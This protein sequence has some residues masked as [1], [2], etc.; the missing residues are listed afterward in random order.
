METRK[1]KL[2]LSAGALALS[3]ALAGCGGGG[4]GGSPTAVTDPPP[5]T[6]AEIDRDE[7]Q[8]NERLLGA[9]DTAEDALGIATS[10]LMTLADDDKTDGSA[11][12][13]AMKYSEM[14]DTESVDGNSKAAMD[15][16]AMVL[17]ARADLMSYI[18]MTETAITDLKTARD[19]L[20]DGSDVAEINA[21]IK[22]A[23]DLVEAAQAVLD[24]TGSGSLAHYVEMVTGDDEDDMKDAADKGMEVAMAVAMALGPAMPEGGNVGDQ[25]DGAGTRVNTDRDDTK[26]GPDLANVKMANRA[27][28]PSHDPMSMTWEQIVGAD[29]VMDMRI[30]SDENDTDEVKAASFDGMKASA[31]NDAL[32]TT[33][34]DGAE[35]AATNEAKGYMGIPG[36]VFCQGSCKVEMVDGADTLTGDW[37][38]TPASTTNVYKKKADDEDMYVQ[39]LMVATFGHWL[40]VD[41]GM[42]TADNKGQVTVN[43]YANTSA[44]DDNTGSWVVD[45]NEKHLKDAEATYNGTAIGRSV[46]KTL[47]GDGKRTDI[48]SGRFEA[49]VTLTAEFGVNPMLGGTIDNFEGTDNPMAVDP[50][51]TVKLMK[52]RVGADTDGPGEVT[53][54]MT[55]A[56]GQDGTWSAQSY[57][58]APTLTDKDARMRPEGIF[59]LFNAHFTDG[60]VAGAYATRKD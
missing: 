8:K 39:D 18:G 12:M 11:L 29:N 16:A 43:T 1:M 26:V 24:K 3:L 13:M 58:V 47:D 36:T 21:A 52:T 33:I 17:Q 57:G 32:P 35:Y 38:F 51:W 25:A 5:K 10:K 45:Q 34:P 54:G 48:Q 2:A 41:D 56:T 30:A 42:V 31:I 14:L 55:K 37:F 40:V 22:D 15:N 28:L 9:V 23:E 7:A 53:G 60:H 27:Q 50:N 46:H 19:E 4:S 59:G 44:G 20:P 6:Q 49:D